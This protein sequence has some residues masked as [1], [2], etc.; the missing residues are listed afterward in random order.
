MDGDNYFSVDEAHK[1]ELLSGKEIG[2]N[3]CEL[4]RVTFCTLAAMTK[5][6]IK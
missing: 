4:I 2:M 6:I 3:S 5:A 1:Q